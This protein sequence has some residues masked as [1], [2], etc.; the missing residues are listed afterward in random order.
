LLFHVYVA[1][2]AISGIALV[3]I[4]FIRGGQTNAARVINGVLGAVFLGYAFYLAFIFT[5]GHY[6]LSFYAFVLP[7]LLIFRF[8]RTLGNRPPAAQ[9]A[10]QQ[11]YTGQPFRGDAF[12]GPQSQGERYG[13]QPYGGPPYGSQ[14]PGTQ[15]YGDQ[16][17][18]DQAYGG[19]PHGGAQ[20]YGGQTYGN[21]PYRGPQQGQPYR[22]HQYPGQP[23]QGR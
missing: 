2:L 18:G 19:Q 23:P 3:A 5:G 15:P 16:P 12:Q 9:R 6:L 1:F 20:P 22:H 4:A 13:G 11:P 17:Y 14:P 21:Q 7:V 8:V 10:G